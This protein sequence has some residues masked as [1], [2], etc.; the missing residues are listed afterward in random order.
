MTPE[1]TSKSLTMTFRLNESVL[2]RMKEE[3]ENHD[4]SLNTSKDTLNGI[5]M[6]LD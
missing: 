6:N 3:A 2:K 5:A 1:N 4:I